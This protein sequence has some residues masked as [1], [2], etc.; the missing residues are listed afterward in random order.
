MYRNT[1]LNFYYCFQP[2]HMISRVFGL[3]PFTVNLAPNGNIK[4]VTVGTFDLFWFI[5]FI[6]VISTVS[7]VVTFSAKLTQIAFESSFIIFY[8]QVFWTG[9]CFLLFVTAAFDMI[10]RKRFLGIIQNFVT[11]DKIVRIAKFFVCR[12]V[13]VTSLMFFR[14]IESLGIVVNFE[15]MRRKFVTATFVLITVVTV[16][17]IMSLFTLNIIL[18]DTAQYA[19]VSVYFSYILQKYV[20]ACTAQ[21]HIFLLVSFSFPDNRTIVQAIFIYFR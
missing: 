13:S 4:S 1:R 19:L 14:Q 11:F 10:N 17:V 16:L 8:N 20:Y 6:A 3:L 2:F 12:K 7:Y 5:S 21:N 9:G 18:E 15:C